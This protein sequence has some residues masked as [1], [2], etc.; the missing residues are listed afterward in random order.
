MR[1]SSG[2]VAASSHGCPLA[3][4]GWLFLYLQKPRAI[5]HNFSG[6]G[7]ERT[8]A[9]FEDSFLMSP[10]FIGFGPFTTNDE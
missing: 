10:V 4:G 6:S 2:W 7:A 1:F 9:L 8:S 5:F 3:I